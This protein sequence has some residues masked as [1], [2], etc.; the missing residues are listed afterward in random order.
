[1]TKSE[2]EFQDLT[3][4]GGFEYF[5]KK[6]CEPVLQVLRYVAVGILDPVHSKPVV[7]RLCLCKWIIKPG[8]MFYSSCKAMSALNHTVN[9]P[10]HTKEVYLMLESGSQA[11]QEEKDYVRYWNLCSVHYRFLYQVEDVS[12]ETSRLTYA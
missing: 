7:S 10:P 6:F 9:P 12:M 11:R 4:L 3:Q 8:R 1:M 2:N 5:I